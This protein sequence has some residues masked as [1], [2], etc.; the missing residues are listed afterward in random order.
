MGEAES[1]MAKPQPNHSSEKKQGTCGAGRCAPFAT[2]ALALLVVSGAIF[3]GA[4]LHALQWTTKEAVLGTAALCIAF[5]GLGALLLSR[6]NWRRLGR[7]L[8]L[9]SARESEQAEL[10]RITR[11]YAALSHVNQ[12]IMRAEG[13]EPVLDAVCAALVDHGG[14]NIAWI[15][16]VDRE[17]SVV[18]PQVERGDATGLFRKIQI[19][20]DE[21]PEGMGPS[22]IAIRE[23]RPIVCNDVLADP[24]MELWRETLATAGVRAVASFPIPIHG[25]IW[26]V[27]G[28]CSKE[29]NFF[30]EREVGLVEEAASDVAFALTASEREAE[31]KAAVEELRQKQAALVESEQRLALA[32]RAADQGMYDLDLQTGEAVVNEQYARM[33]GYSPEDFAETHE[34]WLERMHPEDRPRLKAEFE[35]YIRGEAPEYRA[36]FRQRTASGEWKWILS[37]G[38]I[39]EWDPAR[40][41]LR[42]VGTHTDITTRKETEETLR[43]HHGALHAAANAIVIT[44]RQGNIE[45]V[46]PAFTRLTGYAME[47][48]LGK[49]PRILKSGTHEREYY[50]NLWQTILAG[51][52]W[53]GELVNKRKDGTLIIEEAVITPVR[54]S[55]GE[56]A[57]FVAVKQDV[58]RR[59][60][61]EDKIAW[62]ARLLDLADDG[63]L[64]CDAQNVVRYWNRG[65]ERLYGWTAG[66]TIGRDL[67][68]LLFKTPADM[69]A[70]RSATVENGASRGE[71]CHLRRDESEV[72]VDSRWTL[73][74]DGSSGAASFLLVN[75]DLTEMK[76]LETQFLRAQRMEAIGTLSSGVAHDINNILA[77]ILMATEL[78]KGAVKG[79]SGTNFLDLIEQSVHRGA[80]IVKQLLVFGRGVEGVRT[81]VQLKHLVRDMAKMARETFPPQVE[82][83]DKVGANLPAVM[84]DIT[85]MHQVLLNLCVN[86]RDAMPNG[87]TLSISARPITLP[88]AGIDMPPDASAGPCLLLEVRDTGSGIPPEIIGKIFDPFFTTKPIGRG[89]GLGLSTVIGIVRSHGGFVEV[90]STMGEGTSFKVYLPAVAEPAKEA[91]AQDRSSPHGAG[92]CVLLVEDEASVRTVTQ[93]ILEKNGYRVVTACNGAEGL[94]EFK[95][96]AAQIRIIVTDMMMPV[97]GGMAFIGEVRKLDAEVPIIALT[98]LGHSLRQEEI[99][100]IA[101]LQTKPCNPGVLLRLI[102]SALARRRPEIPSA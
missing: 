90:A 24:A 28:V 99:R 96:H 12:A 51:D 93:A 10:K 75:T 80:D 20:S 32:L 21:R 60:E 88:A 73:L 16:R 25:T 79:G 65:A 37:M 17:T 98:G 94:I 43:L 69:E 95:R 1:P 18:L 66:E 89:T 57:H 55:A 100:K 82:I 68:R 71:F 11:L 38:A 31:R 26:G 33:L 49:N 102:H 6:R 101:I 5:L 50:R 9:E 97:M 7:R 59:R 39:I 46:N 76:K 30:G 54:N 35:A 2:A 81:P 58:T 52:V 48:V 72:I 77:P 78:L 14:F 44:N 63:I 85:Q 47:E 40:R 36:E 87:G 91:P 92:E 53:E 19:Y 64:V 3:A 27:L 22:G 8:R 62:Q 83:Q 41:P 86:A 61:A 42:M 74:P 29:P 34:R 13:Q 56:I 67:S 84:A 23:G 70:A 15:G 45:W 4:E